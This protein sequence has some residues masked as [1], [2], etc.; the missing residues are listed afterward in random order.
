V[1]ILGVVRVN[2]IQFSSDFWS[3]LPLFVALFVRCSW[4]LSYRHAHGQPQQHSATAAPTPAPAAV[5]AH[6]STT[7]SWDIETHPLLCARFLFVGLCF[8]SHELRILQRC[9]AVFSTGRCAY[10]RSSSSASV[11]SPTGFVF[12]ATLFV[13]SLVA[14]P[15]QAIVFELIKYSLV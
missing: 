7:R 1:Q 9:F 12:Q 4:A 14:A 15:F 11:S 13:V 2:L 10:P 8:L 6:Q 3:R 5:R